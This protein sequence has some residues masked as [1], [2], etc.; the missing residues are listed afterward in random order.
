MST[1]EPEHA[2]SRGAWSP[3]HYS[4]NY[5][6]SGELAGPPFEGNKRNFAWRFLLILGIRGKYFRRSRECSFPLLAGEN[7]RCGI[8]LL[9]TNLNSN[10]GVSQQV[11]IPQRMFW[12]ASFR[13]YC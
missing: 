11:V 13:S 6:T 7:S 2:V 12:A 5:S 4:T 8:K 10:F 3:K 1:L 9:A